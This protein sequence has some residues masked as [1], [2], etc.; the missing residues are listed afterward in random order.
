MEQRTRDLNNPSA[1]EVLDSL[2]F[3]IESLRSSSSKDQG[4]RLSTHSSDSGINSPFALHRLPALSPAT[5]LEITN[6][7]LS[8]PQLVQ[9]AQPSPKIPF[10]AI[11]HIIRN[12]AK[13]C[14]KEPKHNSSQPNH[15][16]AQSVLR[17]RTRQGYKLL[18][19]LQLPHFYDFYT[20]LFSI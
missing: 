20:S 14:S 4:K 3:P 2:P 9:N 16:D 8:T 13:L 5:L 19:P 6:P 12:S 17:T 7:H 10:G 15:P 18:F 1:T 11:H